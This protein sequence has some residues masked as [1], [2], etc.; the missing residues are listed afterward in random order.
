MKGVAFLLFK[1][2]YVILLSI[3]LLFAS[4][5]SGYQAETFEEQPVDLWNVVKPLETTASFLNTGAHP[6][7]ERSDLLAYLSRGLGV[8]TASLIANRGEGGQNEI[9]SELGNAL[10][11]IRSRELIE[12]SKVTGVHVFH[13]SETTNDP[14]Y[15]FGFSKTPEETLTKWG[16]ETTYERFI[17]LIRTYKPDIVMPSFRDV[18]TQHGHHRAITQL[19]LKAFEDAANPNV[20][21]EQIKKGL[22]PWQVKKLYLP[23]ETKEQTTTSFDIGIY[24]PI[25]GM[26][27]PQLGEKSRYLHKSQ[28]MGRDIPA[29]P[30]IINLQL[31]KSVQAIT[32]EDTLFKGIPYNFAEWADQLPKKEQSLKTYLVK[33]QKQLDHIVSLYPNRQDIFKS[34]HKT[35]KTVKQVTKKVEKSSLSPDVKTDLLHKLSV[36]QNQLEQVSFTAS[37]LNVKTEINS[38]ILSQGETTTVKVHISNDGTET[39]KNVEVVVH[40]PDGWKTDK[41]QTIKVL[42]GRGHKVLSFKVKVPDDA[43]YYDPYKSGAVHVNISYQYNGSKAEHTVAPETTVAVLPEVSLKVEPENLVVNTIDVQE[44]IPVLVK[45]KNYV[46]GKTNANISLK[47]P[48]G[49]KTKPASQLVHFEKQN[50]ATELT[51]TLIP[52]KDVEKGSFQ[53]KAIAT[54]NKKELSTTVQEIQYDHIG[55]FYYLYDS[56]VKGVA[57]ELFKPEGLKIGYIESGFDK[58]ADVLS[59]IGFNIKKLTAEDL[60]N[61]DLKQYDTIITGIRAYLSRNDLL[62]HQ[63]R[64]LQYVENGGH[65]VVQYHKPEDR[66]DPEK[67]APYKLVIGQPSIRWR[68]TDENAKVTV[69]KPEHPLFNYPNKITDEDW[70]NWVQERGLYYPMEWDDRYET[71]VSMADPNEQPFDGG[72]LM[73]HYGKGTYLYTNLVLYRQIQ[74]QVPGGYRIFTNLISYPKVK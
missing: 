69:L 37:Q 47:V 43:S 64:L 25:Y 33:L 54:V 4:L 5:P 10:G 27:Y 71:F 30:R 29:E 26:T 48:E 17:R 40:V 18:D 38:P 60:A 23:A 2:G 39:L 68:V 65:L 73:A 53:V 62:Q 24:D 42:K 44:E 49:W 3:L 14:I 13:L 74:S 22:S 46:N 12:A 9:G 7:D 70:N 31:V 21:P 1:K 20:F 28:G 67:S 19:S 16:E 66:W 58:V 36:K 59:N 41:K 51:F 8:Q 52:P 55:K 34:T 63:D 72:I 50:Q 35:I 56:E 6:D 45:V 61:G 11:I 15:D 57:F 32:S